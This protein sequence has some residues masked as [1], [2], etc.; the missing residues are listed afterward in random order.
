[1]S[2]PWCSVSKERAERSSDMD[3][4]NEQLA[5]TVV[6]DH[7]QRAGTARRGRQIALERRLSRRAERA[8]AS[9][10]VAAARSL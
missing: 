1:M 3:Y 8:A 7:L 5:R 6:A 10:R 9:A 2:V 4:A